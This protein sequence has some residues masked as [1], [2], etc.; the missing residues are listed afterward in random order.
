MCVLGQSCGL[1]FGQLR[2]WN[3][4]GMVLLVVSVRLLV[5][6]CAIE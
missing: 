5:P 2:I 4:S 1:V 6:G 3:L